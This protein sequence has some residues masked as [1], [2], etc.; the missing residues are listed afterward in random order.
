MTEKIPVTVL[1]GYLGAGKT[2]LLN[3]V[4][5]NRENKKIAVIVNDMSEVNIDAS[6]VKKGGFSRTDEKLV[7]LQNGCICCTLRED[8]MIEVEKLVQAG[9][10]DYILIES[11]GIS[12]PIPVAQTFTYVDESLGINLSDYCRL[13]TMATVVDANRFWHDFASGETLL[14][15]KQ[16]T[17]ESDTREVVDLLIDQIEFANVIVLNKIDLVDKE[18]ARELKAVLQ[19]LNPSANVIESSHSEIN[20]NEILDTS[21]FDLEEASQGAGWIKEL[22]EEHTPETEEYGISSFV[23]RRKRP[24]HPERWRQWLE[25]WPVDIVRAKGFFWL[26]TRNNI[27]GLL[28]QAGPSIVLQ[29]AGE[30]IAAYPDQEREQILKDE[31]ELLERWDPEFGDRMTEL[32][33]IGIGMKQ[34]NIERSLDACLLTEEE[35]KE[36]WSSFKD[37]LPQF[38]VEA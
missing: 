17:D 26:A 8:L 38:E 10:I 2:T 34:A 33:M 9:D 7:E 20:L 21:L 24:F 11:S 35:L 36:D 25:D 23:Y 3:H 5:K 30:W 14:D 6:M 16:G 15:R 18:A 22:N 1:S 37:P 12:E 28:S 32:V 31:P 19:K 4:L 29:G 13:D 27:T